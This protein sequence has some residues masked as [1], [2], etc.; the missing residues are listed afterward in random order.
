M[1]EPADEER[2]LCQVEEWEQTLDKGIAELRR[3]AHGVD[4]HG[5]SVSPEDQRWAI[6][7]LL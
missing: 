6:Q 1:T 2:L 5:Y 3:M 7:R 4:Q